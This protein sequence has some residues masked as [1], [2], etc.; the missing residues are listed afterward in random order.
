MASDNAAYVRA[1]LVIIFTPLTDSLPGMFDM[2][3]SVLIQAFIA[4]KS[5]K[6]INKSV[7]AGLPGWL[8]RSPTPFS[9]DY[10]SDALQVN[11]AP[12][13]LF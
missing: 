13:P 4:K 6:A 9:R 11:S 8:R 2:A 12:G 3:E 5:I 7:H 1:A 10:W